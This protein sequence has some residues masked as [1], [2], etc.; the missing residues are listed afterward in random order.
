MAVTRRNIVKNA[1]AR[2]NYVNGVKLLK[3][4]SSARTTAEFGIAGPPSPVS[5]YDLFVI[6]HQLTMMFPRINIRSPNRCK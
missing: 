6:W 3:Q 2:A 1:A 5:T 4:E